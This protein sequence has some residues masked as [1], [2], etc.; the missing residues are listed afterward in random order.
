[1]KKIVLLC[2]CGLLPLLATS[3]L[4]ETRYVIDTL[5]VTLRDNPSDNYQNLESL[6]TATPVEILEEGK[7]FDKVR[8]QKGNEGYVLK[9]YL[10]AD[11]PKKIVISNL[12]QQVTKLQEQLDAQKKA[13]AEKSDLASSNQSQ[14]EATA[15]ELATTKQQLDKVNGEFENLKERAKNVLALSTERDQLAEENSRLTSEMKVLQEENQSF[16]RTNS[17]QWFLAGGGVFL[18]G[19]L[20]GK[21]S[22]KKR[23]FSR[24]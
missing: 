23:G 13:Y 7:T 18:V 11:T 8:T 14:N 3:A 6:S 5:I 21:I 19:W 15:K 24:L 4:A 22:R 9:Q 17:I 12:Q 20:I 16:H 1:M 10:T 2:F